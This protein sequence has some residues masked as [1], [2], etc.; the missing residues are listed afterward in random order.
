MLPYQFTLDRDVIISREVAMIF[1]KKCLRY[2]IKCKNNFGF[3]WRCYQLWENKQ[4]K[5][6]VYAYISVT[7]FKELLL[8]RFDNCVTEDGKYMIEI[9]IE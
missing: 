5:E 1:I 7:E 6:N 3:I 9:N 2:N 4:Y 8:F